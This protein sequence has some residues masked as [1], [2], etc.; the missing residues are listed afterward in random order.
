M[1][2][3]I[4]FAKEEKRAELKE[5]ALKKLH[6]ASDWVRRY[7]YEIA[8]YGPVVLAGT[9]AVVK[10][11]GRRVNLRKEEALK[12]LYCYDRSLGHYWR[13]RRPLSNREWVSIERRRKHGERLADILDSM[14]VLK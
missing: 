6:Q 10:T 14:N 4:H 7:K 5:K 8:T 12:N 3:V 1:D 2:N 11:V 9:A 13:L